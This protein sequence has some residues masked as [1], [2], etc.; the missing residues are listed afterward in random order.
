L[1]IVTT[2]LSLHAIFRGLGRSL[3]EGVSTDEEEEKAA[4][5]APDERIL[6]AGRH[7]V[8]AESVPL[9]HLKSRYGL[10]DLPEPVLRRATRRATPIARQ[11]LE[12]HAGLDHPPNEEGIT[13]LGTVL[14]SAV[15]AL[16]YPRG[17]LHEDLLG[18]EEVGL[19]RLLESEARG[20][21]DGLLLNPPV[22]GGVGRD[23]RRR[24]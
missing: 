14:P 16:V 18:A 19:T 17:A 12:G 20:G 11:I 22:G 23:R 21:I 7:R 13:L 24:R 3:G 1:Y 10:H 5:T 6:L 4:Y 2:S 9:I 8:C 15:G